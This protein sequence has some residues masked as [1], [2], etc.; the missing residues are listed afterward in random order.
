MQEKWSGSLGSWM[1][2][3]FWKRRITCNM[4]NVLNL[5]GNVQISQLRAFTSD[6][7]KSSKIELQ[8]KFYIFWAKKTPTSV[9]VK[10]C[11]DVQIFPWA[12]VTVYIYM[13]TVAC[14]SINLLFFSLSSPHSL[15]FSFYSHLSLRSLSLASSIPWEWSLPQASSPSE[16]AKSNQPIQE[17]VL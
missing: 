2:L 3:S 8:Y 17:E 5:L 4:Q 7:L 1:P 13:V 10:M 12:T 6:H 16:G 9:G 11:K 14:L 15:L